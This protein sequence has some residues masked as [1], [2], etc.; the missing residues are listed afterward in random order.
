MLSSEPKQ[1]IQG[2]EALIAR[3]P[4]EHASLDL[5]SG[6][7]LNQLLASYT[8]IFFPTCLLCWPCLRGPKTQATRIGPIACN[9]SGQRQGKEMRG[10]LR[11]KAL[12]LGTDVKAC[13]DYVELPKTMLAPSIRQHSDRSYPPGIQLSAFEVASKSG[14]HALKKA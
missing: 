14:S 2:A 10:K 12:S 5:P 11:V 13:E 7:V 9:F 4:G 8:Q 3:L 6:F 1:V